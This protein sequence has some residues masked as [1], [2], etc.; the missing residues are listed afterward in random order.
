MRKCSG[1]GM[2]VAYQYMVG[3]LDFEIRYM[4]TSISGTRRMLGYSQ[5]GL[6]TYLKYYYGFMGIKR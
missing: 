1:D 3:P 6:I 5:I 2:R 4:L